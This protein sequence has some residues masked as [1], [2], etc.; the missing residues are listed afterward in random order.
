MRGNPGQPEHKCLLHVKGT[1]L[2]AQPGGNRHN[3]LYARRTPCRGERVPKLISLVGLNAVA[4]ILAL[5]ITTLL[6]TRYRF[7]FEAKTHL[8]V[9]MI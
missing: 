4:T 9:T 8:A 1:K 5:G 7:F 6:S 2:S 3:N